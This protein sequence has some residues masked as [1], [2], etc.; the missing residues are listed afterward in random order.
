[1][2][3]SILDPVGYVRPAY[4]HRCGRRA[5]RRVSVRGPARVGV[6][7]VMSISR[8]SAGAGYR[9]LLKNI[10]VGDVALAPR[11]RLTTYYA[12]SGNPPGRWMGSGLAGLAPE[13]R[14]RAL[15]PGTV[16]AEEAMAAL[17]GAG[18]N[19]VTGEQLGRPYPTYKSAEDRIAEAIAGLPAE[20]SE[21][22]RQAAI[23]AIE[24]HVAASPTR[25]AVAGFDLTFTAPKSASIFWAL[26][27]ETVQ[28]AVVEAHREALDTVLQLVEDRF[29][30]TRS[31]RTAPPPVVRS[32]GLAHPPRP[33]ASPGRSGA[34]GPDYAQRCRTG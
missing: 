1:M 9:Y 27:D 24:A 3:G 11:E 13:L 32:H 28:D 23:A 5:V 17:Y 8:L 4:P 34:A 18:H 26:G 30:F 2:R 14:E 19:P 10:A 29:L 33:R 31:G 15:L 20:L 6:V 22:A 7:A 21:P 25:S 16:V 12:A